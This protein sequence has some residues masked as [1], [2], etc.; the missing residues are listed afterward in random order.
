MV[1]VEG[2]AGRL[3]ER[4]APRELCLQE[5]LG[6]DSEGAVD[7][8]L[9]RDPAARALHPSV[10]SAPSAAECAFH[11]SPPSCFCGRAVGSFG[12]GSFSIKVV[13]E[14]LQREYRL[15]LRLN[16]VLP[17][18]GS[19]VCCLS[20]RASCAGWWGW[21]VGCCS[22]SAS[23]LAS[24]SSARR[25]HR[26]RCVS[27]SVGGSHSGVLWLL[28]MA[29]I[30]CNLR[31]SAA[32]RHSWAVRESHRSATPSGLMGACC[33]PTSGTICVLIFWPR[34]LR[35][36]QKTV[37]VSPATSSSMVSARVR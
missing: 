20:Q 26:E 4:S 15:E 7:Q 12:A 22:L 23:V 17:L 8:S 13:A 5:G 37:S 14:L 2:A 30:C 16:L 31:A 9:G 25:F 18:A 1:V 24:R 29:L 36:P 28:H 19:V 10:R 33:L 3:P 32:R 21:L 6:G 11:P 35:C 34:R 27:A